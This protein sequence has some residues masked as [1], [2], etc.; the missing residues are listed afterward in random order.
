MDARQSEDLLNHF[1]DVRRFDIWQLYY[2][3]F[4]KA[5]LLG[6]MTIFSVWVFTGAGWKAV[7]FGLAFFVISIFNT[8][9]RFL[10]P[11]GLLVFCA[12]VAYDCDQNFFSHVRSA[13]GQ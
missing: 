4:F 9:R 11:I 12:A 3:A 10:E 7:F 1:N 5:I 13:L 2:R 6:L 8:W